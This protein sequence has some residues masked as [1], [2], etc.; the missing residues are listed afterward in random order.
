MI[1]PVARWRAAALLALAALLVAC[2]GRQAAVARTVRG[3]DAARAAFV[4]WDG[5]HQLELVAAA[6]SP[7]DGRARLTAYRARRAPV[8]D[9]FALAYR[10]AALA[11]LDREAGL[12]EM[13]AAAAA[14][15]GA[16]RD[17]TTDARGKP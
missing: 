4:A 3:L 5:R 12:G 17:L 6:T 13:A 10:A 2:G 7:D 11:A 16:A 14:A 15:I 8:V 1:A 9:A